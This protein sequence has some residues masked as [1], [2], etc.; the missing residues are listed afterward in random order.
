MIFEWS[1]VGRDRAEPG[2]LR[3]LPPPPVVVWNALI[4]EDAGG[5]TLLRGPALRQESFGGGPIRGTFVAPLDK[6]AH[7]LMISALRVSTIDKIAVS[8]WR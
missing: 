7:M 6:L 4:L 3:V 2:T 1:E 5:G 8:R